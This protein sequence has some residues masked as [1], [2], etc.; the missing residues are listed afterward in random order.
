[1]TESLR[2][3]V[4]P[5]SLKGT[6]TAIE[7][8]D[9]ITAGIV[10]VVPA[11]RIARMPFADGGEG[12]VDAVIAAG[13]AARVDRV[14]GPLGEPV[15]A[16]WALLG[17][18]AV[19]EMAAAS[20]IGLVPQTRANALAA[21]TFGTGALLLRAVAAG[22]RR[23]VLGVGGSATTDGGLGAL[24]AL[25][26]RAY[27]GDGEEVR[28]GGAVLHRIRRIDVAPARAALDGVEIVLCSDVANPF[29]G[30]GGAAEVFAP[31]KGADADGVAALDAGLRSWAQVLDATCGSD[32]ATAGWGGSG[33]GIAG[34]LQVAVGATAADGVEVVADAL[35]LDAAIAASD[36]VVVA[37][38]SLD[39]QS[40]LG[41]A[42]VGIARHARAAGAP[43]IAVAGRIA[44]SRDALLAAG[45]ADA[46]SAVEAAGGV[47]LA[48]AEPARWLRAA[49]VAL[50]ERNPGLL[51]GA[52]D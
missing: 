18:T 36:L 20:G 2:V 1:M 31:Q 23:I 3:L 5:D 39:E 19:V 27:D 28:G 21:D 46:T 47:D 40:L 7:A 10:D 4:A 13:A 11:A 24:R 37:E 29:A 22:A 15:D 33:G 14:A 52:R 8:A 51:H 9:A 34:G 41:K 26:A 45:I 6:L 49:T 17:D 30:P 44:A 32:L 25:G 16:R 42:P 48:L 43:C 50:L 38:G 35:G 12:T